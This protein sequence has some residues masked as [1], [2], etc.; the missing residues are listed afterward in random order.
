[1]PAPNALYRH[2]YKLPA[3]C[4]LSFEIGGNQPHVQSYWRYRV[5][6]DESLRPCHENDLVDELRGLLAQAVRRRLMSDVP[7]GIF[8]S[9][10]LD[11]SAILAMA[12]AQCHNR[13]ISS[14]SIGFREPSFDEAAWARRVARVMGSC[15]HEEVLSVEAMRELTAEILPRLDEPLGDASILPTYWLSR[16]ARRHITVALG[17]DGGDEL[18]A[19]YDPFKALRPALLYH[20]CV[21]RLVHRGLRCLVDLLP[22]STRNM[23]LD[24][25]LRRSLVGLSYPPHL[26]NPVWL[27]PLEPDAIAE[28]FHDQVVLEDLYSEAIALWH[29]SNATNLI[30]HTLEFYAN[31]YLPDNILTKVDRASMMVSLEVRAPFLDND[32]VAFACRLPHAW[33][34]RQGVRKYLLKKA[35]QGLLPAEIVYR[36]KKGFG[37]PLVD[38]LRQG[39]LEPPRR[40]VLGADLNW[41]DRCWREHRSGAADHRLFLWSWLGVQ[42]HRHTTSA[43]S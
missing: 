26:W 23:S 29:D 27:G 2:T 11:S 42:Y 3:A 40:P 30:D 8:L 38:W 9:G 41:V 28:L 18:F 19:G 43:P 34:M 1:L 39:P 25:Q 17:G 24:F 4:Y 36:R 32:L 10:G 16:F 14:F 33:K 7:L 12:S 15:H 31:L 13:A 5:E 35:L 21:P 20:A 37:I 22:I 6:P